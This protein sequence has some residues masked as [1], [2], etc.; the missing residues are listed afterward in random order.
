MVPKWCLKMGYEVLNY[1]SNLKKAYI[2]LN[3]SVLWY[4]SG[5][6]EELIF[7]LSSEPNGLT[8]KEK[9]SGSSIENIK[10]LASVAQLI[11]PSRKVSQANRR[12]DQM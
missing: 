10:L 4:R 8:F 2:W 7:L 12:P 9:S 6:P 3:D 1:S 11:A 5:N